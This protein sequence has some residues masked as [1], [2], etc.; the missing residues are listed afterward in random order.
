MQPLH[1]GWCFPGCLRRVLC[2]QEC[3]FP[4][5]NSSTPIESSFYVCLSVVSSSV[6]A[7]PFCVSSFSYRRAWKTSPPPSQNLSRNCSTFSGKPRPV[8]GGQCR[9][10][11]RTRQRIDRTS[12]SPFEQNDQSGEPILSVRGNC[13][14]TDRAVT[15]KRVA[16]SETR[17]AR[18]WR[19]GDALTHF[20]L[21]FI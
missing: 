2:S 7:W 12:R 5:F 3:G 19:L 21:Q 4:R 6:C 18:L 13:A 10:H 15:V 17:E 14:G 20:S 8:R 9:S 1:I 16:H 11:V